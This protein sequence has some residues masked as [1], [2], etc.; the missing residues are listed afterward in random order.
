MTATIRGKGSYWLGSQ[1]TTGFLKTTDFDVAPVSGDRLV[2]FVMNNDAAAPCISSSSQ[3]VQTGSSS[4][5]WT[6]LGN[7]VVGAVGSAV[8]VYT[9]I[10]NGTPGTA[11]ITVSGRDN[12]AYAVVG[13]ALSG[14]G[15]PAI[16]LFGTNTVSGT[17]PVAGS[18][19]STGDLLIT[20]FGIN[21]YGTTAPTAPGAPT[22]QTALKNAVPGTAV[23]LDEVYV[24]TFSQ[25][26]GTPGTRVAST[27]P[28]PGAGTD[29]NNYAVSVAIPAGVATPSA[30][31]GWGVL[32]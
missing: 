16:G 20:A 17:A 1:Q 3:T 32:L 27:W 31:Y 14:A 11:L 30:K 8:G 13:V 29:P 9:A 26:L 22:G 4:Q 5:T 18:V 23:N 19:G 7:N 15:T 25:V 28:N 10:Y 12:S 21:C 6:Q 2:V 24:Y